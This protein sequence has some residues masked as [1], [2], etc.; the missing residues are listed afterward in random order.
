MRNDKGLKITQV[1]V[2]NDKDK[3]VY[4]KMSKD[5]YDN[6]FLKYSALINAFI[7]KKR[8]VPE[9]LFEKYFLLFKRADEIV[10]D[11]YEK[12]HN[13]LMDKI[14]ERYSKNKDYAFSYTNRTTKMNYTF[15][16]MIL[17]CLHETLQHDL[18][19]RPY[20]KEFCLKVSYLS[21]QNYKQ[22]L[23]KNIQSDY[24]KHYKI[25]VLSAY[26]AILLGHDRRFFFIQ[27]I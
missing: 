25:S 4:F 11:E 2:L 18:V 16:G 24:L 13:S 26:I 27:S 10:W 5:D 15:K 7:S 14:L 1:D 3:A 9:K 6:K 17:E 21:M 23:P 22:Q 8:P 19:E 20:K 12:I